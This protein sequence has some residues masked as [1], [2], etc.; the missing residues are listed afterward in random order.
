[1]IC[2]CGSLQRPEQLRAWRQSWLQEICV[3]YKLD[4][5]RWS[6]SDIIDFEHF[7]TLEA[8]GKT[9][10]IPSGVLELGEKGVIDRKQVF[11]AWL[12][13]KR[14]ETGGSTP[15]RTVERGFKLAIWLAAIFGLVAGLSLC[16]GLLFHDRKN[17]VDVLLF[18]FQTLCI[19]VLLL[20]AAI[21]AA[22]RISRS[23]SG[24]QLVAGIWNA[25]AL[26]IGTL[27]DHLPGRKRLAIKEL[28]ST[29]TNR[30]DLYGHILIWPA[31]IAAQMFMVFFNLGLILVLQVGW[32][33]PVVFAWGSSSSRLTPEGVHRAASVF[34]MPWSWLPAAYPDDSK[35]ATTK[36]LGTSEISKA[37]VEA[38]SAWW[39]FVA[40]AIGFYGL[41]PRI[42]LL[43]WARYRDLKERNGLQFSHPECNELYRRLI[44]P[45]IVSGPPGPTLTPLAEK[46]AGTLPPDGSCWV[47]L[48][49]AGRWRGRR[50]G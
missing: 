14:G 38:G 31:V 1:M 47:L 24:F 45:L 23:G 35:V 49:F 2:G 26:K 28:F 15:G 17:P 7:L 5:M 40:Y 10:N 50:R 42:A 6:L 16:W 37:D 9:S 3:R 22:W 34:A 32:I 25:I 48:G 11:A 13:A 8:N 29:L 27:L 21:L 19:Q 33:S 44:P 30:H 39:P 36:F 41:L 46:Q 43:A 20:M 18:L 12:A 4:G